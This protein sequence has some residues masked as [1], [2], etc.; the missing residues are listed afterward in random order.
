MSRNRKPNRRVRTLHFESL[1]RR[2]VMSASPM[3][4]PDVQALLAPAA[5]ATP[6]ATMGPIAR[7]Q[8]TPA[9]P[10]VAPAG[11]IDTS[12]GDNG[13]WHKNISE[14]FGGAEKV[15]L[16]SDGS[17]RFL[18]GGSDGRD[19]VITRHFA[20]GSLD[21]RSQISIATGGRGFLEEN[22]IGSS[23]AEALA[24]AVIE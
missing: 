22:L 5:V 7:L 6:N 10:V 18:I 13:V 8:F 16:L 12:F 2:E 4:P 15:L 11:T 23:K 14:R 24:R 17:G 9:S 21:R 1:E 3:M 19:L 20:N